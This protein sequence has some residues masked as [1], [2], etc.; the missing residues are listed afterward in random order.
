MRVVTIKLKERMKYLVQYEK[1]PAFCYFCGCMGHEVTECGGG[2]HKKESCESGDWL[3]APFV[4]I[5]SGRDDLRGGGGRGR[6]RGGGRG[7]GR[8]FGADDEIEPMD[9][10][11]GDEEEDPNQTLIRK[12][13]ELAGDGSGRVAMQVNLLEHSSQKDLSISPIKEQEK[14]GQGRMEVV[15]RNTIQTQML[16]RRSP[17]RR[18]TGHNE[19]LGLELPGPC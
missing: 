12:S 17:S 6:G 11:L 8:G 18:V 9:T 3:R 16:D 19:N 10:S 5:I 4:P 1:L 7:G 15:R 14:K 2:T 13:E